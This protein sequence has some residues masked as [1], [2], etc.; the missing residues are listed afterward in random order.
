MLKHIMLPALFLS[1]R[2]QNAVICFFALSCIIP[3]QFLTK[4]SLPS[5]LIAVD[6][7]WMLGL[8][9]AWQ[10]NKVFGK[11]IIF[12]YGPLSFLSTRIL[13]NGE[14]GPLI[15]FDAYMACS[16]FY[17]IHRILLVN[18]NWQKI[19]LLLLT[20]F[21]YKQALFLSLVFSMQFIILLYLHEYSQ[22][23]NWALLVQA[24]VLTALIFYIKLNLAFV[25]MLIFLLFLVYLLRLKKLRPLQAV[26]ICLL[27]LL[28]VTG[29]SY[30]LPVDLPSYIYSALSIIDSYNDAVSIYP[31]K[32]M[33][34]YLYYSIS[35]ICI[36]F[37]LCM[38]AYMWHKQF[39]IKILHGI[40]LL[41]LFVMFKQCCVRA[42]LEHLK[43]FFSMF[44]P[45]LMVYVY[46]TNIQI[47]G[48]RTVLLLTW[49]VMIFL[50]VWFRDYSYP[51]KKLIAVPVYFYNMYEGYDYYALSS[52]R[53][54]PDRIRE[55]IGDATVDIIPWEISALIVNNMH[56]SPRPVI[57]SYLSYNKVLADIN[58]QR[59]NSVDAPQYVLYSTGNIDHH[60]HFFD[61]TFIRKTLLSRYHIV[62]TFTLNHEP[63]ILFESM[64]IHRNEDFRLLTSG[65]TAIADSLLV[66]VSK[67]PLLLTYNMH[68]S[69]SG[70]VQRFLVRAPYSALT[71]HTE[72][73]KQHSFQTATT[74]L[75][76]GVFADHYVENT[77]DAVQYFEH[78]SAALK[79]IRSISIHV[80]DAS[81]WASKATYSWYELR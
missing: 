44:P 43:D 26:Y 30:I 39:H 37:V 47:K 24:V 35:G 16:I 31:A 40:F 28:M 49:G 36:W 55:R 13:L 4:L 38:V 70:K 58:Y 63:M 69:F 57:Q 23:A 12:N 50:L 74:I 56:Y 62:D 33:E 7:S 10:T 65:T 80:K 59:Y 79:K 20:C 41:L 73:G 71:L 9:E 67:Y 76:A 22:R 3:L 52:S 68:Y 14:V 15:L 5:D 25:S 8:S 77:A 2:F 19:V 17:I 60:Y 66:P 78:N 51:L 45:F 64:H 42:D 53:I 72:D 32:G 81:A 61:D 18:R 54:F 29:L 46:V 1:V 48:V 27:L 75:Q 34:E 21:F 11:E 6:S